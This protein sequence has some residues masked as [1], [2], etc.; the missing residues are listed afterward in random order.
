MRLWSGVKIIHF[1]RK[2]AYFGVSAIVQVILVL[3][4]KRMGDCPNSSTSV[5]LLLL[6]L[7]SLN[8]LYV[9]VQMG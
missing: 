3:T 4:M 1:A 7:L 6:L 2:L 9:L 5:G 8:V